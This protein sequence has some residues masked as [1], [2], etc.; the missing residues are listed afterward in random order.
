MTRESGDLPSHADSNQGGVPRKE[1]VM[2]TQQRRPSARPSY[3]VVQSAP[4]QILVCKACKPDGT[5]ATTGSVLL[6][7]LRMAVSA[8]GL[9]NNFDV[10]GTACLAGCVPN[11]GGACVVGVR[12]PAKATWLF[13]KIDPALHTDDVIAFARL[14]ADQPDGWLKGKDCPAQLCNNTLARIPTALRPASTVALP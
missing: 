8:A 10:T 6:K 12:A 3:H 14:Y 7:K 2:Q 9:S 5:A 1:Q 4:H 13:G 11:H